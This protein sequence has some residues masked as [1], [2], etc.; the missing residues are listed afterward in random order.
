MNLQCGVAQLWTTTGRVPEGWQDKPAKL[1]QKDRDARWTVKTTKAKPREGA[2]PLVDLAIPAFGYQS[3]ISADRRHRLIRRWLVTDAAA[4]AGARLADLLD[5]GNTAS[6]VWADT[7]YRSK[8]NEDLL[9]ERMLVSQIHRKKPAGRPMPERTAQANAKKSTVR[10]PIEHVFAEQQAR[11]GL[12]DRTIG[13]A[14]ATTQIGLANLA[15][16]MRRLLWLER[17]PAL[18]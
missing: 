13:L 5:P 15:H 17:Q 6:A 8:K 9:R 11:M 18:A 12:F 10:A 3:H 4:H 14:R 7:G 2:T 16:N 1:S